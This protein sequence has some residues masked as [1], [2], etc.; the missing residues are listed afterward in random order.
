MSEATAEFRAVGDASELA[1]GSVNPFYLEDIKQRVSVA[2]VGG[3]LYAFDDLCT[4]ADERCPLSAGRLEG[5]TLMCQCHGS[6]FDLANGAVLRGPAT[7][8]LVTH[9]VR[10]QDGAV[11]IRV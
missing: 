4:C 11:Q 10:E 3:A 9:D 2:R 8:P 5:T 7:Q 1:E 6:Q